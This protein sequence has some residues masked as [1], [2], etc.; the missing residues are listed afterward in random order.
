M[1]SSGRIRRNSYIENPYHG[2]IADGLGMHGHS[3]CRHSS[4]RYRNRKVKE[5]GKCDP[6]PEPD[7]TRAL[8][9]IPEVEQQYEDAKQQEWH[10]SQD[11]PQYP[12]LIPVPAQSLLFESV[13]RGC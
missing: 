1:L 6:E 7:K 4:G 11:I 9:P 8:S 2:Q 10:V 5:K 13:P 12:A 3:K